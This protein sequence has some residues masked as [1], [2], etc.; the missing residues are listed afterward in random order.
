MQKQ[1]WVYKLAKPLDRWL[2]EKKGGVMLEI[3]KQ[4]PE[5][6]VATHQGKEVSLSDLR[7]K[8]V[9]LWFYPK[10]DTPGCTLEG[11]GFRDRLSTFEKYNIE[12]LGVSLDSPQSNRAFAEKFGFRFPLL[13]DTSRQL[14]LAYGAVKTKEDKH[15]SRIGYVIDPQG[16]I[17]RSYPAVDAESF[18]EQVL[19]DLGL[20]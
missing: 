6:R 15:A 17:E 8:R 18:P 5:F 20:S 9:V 16:K 1:K 3:G 7:G 2:S 12:V 10:A 19:K 11:C 13:C 4:A 14:S